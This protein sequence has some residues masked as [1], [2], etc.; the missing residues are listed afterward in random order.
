LLKLTSGDKLILNDVFGEIAY[1]G[2]G[3]FIAGGAGITPFISI[4][5]DLGSRHAIG[6]NKL[7]FANKSKA[8]I[9]YEEELSKLLGNNFINILSG[10]TLPGY[11]HGFITEDFLKEHV[12]DLNVF[13][14][15]CGPP[16]MMD[17]VVKM[18]K[19]LG[20]TEEH[21]IQEGF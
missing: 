9:I 13:F 20:V 21:I 3:V 8:D 11:A 19:N 5:R 1:K 16:P 15:V 10:D 7:L 14:Y 6:R 12:E 2:E 18:L 4:L 17:M